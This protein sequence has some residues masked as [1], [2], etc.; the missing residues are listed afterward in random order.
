MS[1]EQK[2]EYGGCEPDPNDPNICIC[3]EY[4]PEEAG[5]DPNDPNICI[6]PEYPP[7]EDVPPP[8]E[9]WFMLLELNA[10]SYQLYNLVLYLFIWIRSISIK[11]GTPFESANSPQF[12][13]SLQ[14]H[15]GSRNK[16]KDLI[17]WLEIEL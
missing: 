12:Y 11:K 6:C 9:E 15:N 5:P 7:E 4:P 17:H 13:P 2:A 16:R 3:P 10:I 1:N 8:P 14:F